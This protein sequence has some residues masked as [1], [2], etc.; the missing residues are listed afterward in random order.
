MSFR[1]CSL[2]QLSTNQTNEQAQLQEWADPPSIHPALTLPKPN[3]FIPTDFALR[4]DM[5][6]YSNQVRRMGRAVE[7]V[8]MCAHRLVFPARSFYK[9]RPRSYPNTIST[10]K[11]NHSPPSTRHT[12]TGRPPPFRPK[13][14]QHHH[15]H[16][17]DNR[18]YRPTPRSGAQ[19]ARPP[20]I[21]QAR[22]GVPCPE[23]LL[24]RTP[25]QSS[26]TYHI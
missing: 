8:W 2:L 21:P 20:A 12:H 1:T 26:G 18:P 15:Q 10:N 19:G 6:Q 9:N 24:L 13:I 25:P 16:P 5:P 17:R 7:V 3:D 14:P 11:P 4:A 22:H 23:S